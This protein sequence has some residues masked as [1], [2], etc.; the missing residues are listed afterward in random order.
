MLTY[1]E[2]LELIDRQ[3]DIDIAYNSVCHKEKRRI[4]DLQSRIFNNLTKKTEICQKQLKQ[5]L[6]LSL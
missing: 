1:I 4:R 3:K 5:N 2:K 6:P